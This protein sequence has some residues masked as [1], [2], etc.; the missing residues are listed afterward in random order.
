MMLESLAETFH[1]QVD[2]LIYP[3]KNQKKQKLIKEVLVTPLSPKCILISVL[4]YFILYFWG[5]P[6][7][8]QLLM[9]FFG[10]GIEQTWFYQAYWGQILLVFYM[11]FY[12]VLITDYIVSYS[13][14]E[15]NIDEQPGECSNVKCP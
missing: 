13:N 9:K 10:G 1:T 15:P 5:G 14:K 8:T 12:A 7:I 11:A 6:L 2:A 4:T 3:E